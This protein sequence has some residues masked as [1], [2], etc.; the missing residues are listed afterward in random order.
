MK[1]SPPPDEDDSRLFREAIGSVRP[2]SAP[3][4]AAPSRPKPQPEP[5]QFIRDE[6]AVGRELLDH[7]F[8]PASIEVGEELVWL[9]Q[10]QS[11]RLLRR[12]RRG[13]FSV[14]AEIDLH[15]MTAAVARVAI[16][17]FIDECRRENALCVR[18]VHGKGLRSKPEGP[19]LKK[20]TD[21]MLRR[22]ADVLAF[23]SARASEGGTGAVLV[24]LRPL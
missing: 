2:L 16:A 4:Q 21:Q 8:D 14:R 23:A 18:I 22:R 15:Q 7:P 17:Q 6:A 10:G 1:R 13:Q 11:P 20:L 3:A 5:L 24:L 19:V 12:L 9:Q